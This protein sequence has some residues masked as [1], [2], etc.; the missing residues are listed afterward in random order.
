M[1]YSSRYSRKHVFHYAD[2]RYSKRTKEE[3]KISFRS[4]GEAINAGC[5]PCAYCNLINRQYEADQK[6][7]D[8]FCEEFQFKHFLHK[9]ELHGESVQ[10]GIMEKGRSCSMKASIVFLMTAD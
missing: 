4:F 1:F 8:A 9:G 10:A 5:V 2:C 6:A 7:I 3:N